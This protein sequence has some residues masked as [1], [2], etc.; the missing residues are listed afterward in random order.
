[1]KITYGSVCSGIEAATVA[2]EPLGWMPEWFSEIE[3]FP[4]ELLDHHYPNVP[5]LGDMTRLSEMVASGEIGAPDVLVGGTPCQA[6]SVAGLRQGLSDA[7]GAL[8]LAY[9]KLL[10]SI[11]EKRK[12]NNKPSCVA[13]WENVPGVLSSKD[14]AFGCFLGA[15]AGESEPLAPFVKWPKSGFIV[16]PKRV[17]AWRILDAQYFGLAQR[18]KRV[19]VVASSRDGFNPGKALFEQEGLQRH[20]AP[21]REAGEN[22]TPDLNFSLDVSCTGTLTACFGKMG[23]P[24]VDAYTCIPHVT[25][26]LTSNGDEHSGFRDEHGL[27]AIAGN[28]IGRKPE[29]GGN[30]NGFDDS[31][32]M[33]TLT[34]Q[35]RHGV[36][37]AFKAGQGSKAHGIGYSENVVPTLDA[38]GG[39][40]IA[41]VVVRH[42]VRRLTPMECERLQGF[43][44]GYTDIKSNGKPTPD[45]PRYKALGNS[46]AVPVMRWIGV[47]IHLHLLG[48]L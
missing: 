38:S 40:S 45:G 35:D 6:F 48:L 33:Y 5:N 2:W 17:I 18:R 46:M 8:T 41:T 32:I 16:G 31:G 39:N 43:P 22:A 19:F 44:D 20:I 24:E 11:D 4:S 23:A 14:N 34:A 28:I 9:V 7:R 3:T 15:L 29:N 36:M 47:R 42:R 37:A 12:L 1:M 25:S 21:R 26:T 13:V 10:D 30:G 27:I